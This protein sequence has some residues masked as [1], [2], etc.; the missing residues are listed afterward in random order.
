VTKRSKLME[1]KIGSGKSSEAVVGNTLTGNNA[2]PSSKAD[3]SL[4]SDGSHSAI[5]NVATP[6]I[7]S[8][9]SVNRHIWEEELL[10]DIKW[11]RNLARYMFF[12]ALLL[13]MA[14]I[15]IIILAL[16]KGD[17]TFSAPD[18]T[19]AFLSGLG[20]GVGVFWDRVRRDTQDRWEKLCSNQKHETIVRDAFEMTMQIDNKDQRDKLLFEK[21]GALFDAAIKEIQKK[22]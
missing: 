17:G 5:P 12:A 20:G 21:A 4:P 6:V 11:N 14:G 18:A 7:P 9:I 10:N 16:L 13:M 3:P 22:R 1:K 2:E 19:G 15:F 8:L